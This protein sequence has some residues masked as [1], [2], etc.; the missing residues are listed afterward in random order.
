MTDPPGELVNDGVSIW[1]DDLSRQRL[2]TGSLADLTAHGH[3]VGVTTNPTIF[4][5]TI[6]GS[7]KFRGD[8]ANDPMTF[9]FAVPGDWPLGLA[10][11]FAE[12]M[13]KTLEDGFPI[14]DLSVLAHSESIFALATAISACGPTSMRGSRMACWGRT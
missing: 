14:V 2:T 4:A 1:L 6:T 11:A 3:V 10:T 8:S 5:K 7:N 13:E 12:L 9:E